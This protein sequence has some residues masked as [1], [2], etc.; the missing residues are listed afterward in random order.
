MRLFPT[1]S[2][3]NN[4][5]KGCKLVS[6]PTDLSAVVD[7][8]LADSNGQ[9]VVKTP[10]EQDGRVI[11][12]YT[13]PAHPGKPTILLC[14]IRHKILKLLRTGLCI[15]RG[16]VLPVQQRQLAL[17]CLTT[18]TEPPARTN[19]SSYVGS[20][21]GLFQAAVGGL[22]LPDE[23]T[24]GIPDCT[25]HCAAQQEWAQSGRL[26]GGSAGLRCGKCWTQARAEH[27]CKEQT[28]W[29]AGGQGKSAK[30]LL[31]R[32]RWATLGPNFNWTG[33]LTGVELGSS[34]KLNDDVLM[35]CRAKI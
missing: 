25:C 28:G 5:R 21:P 12:A 34:V 22:S 3:R 9:T 2:R 20:L 29:V 4:R 7:L 15:I 6:R 23:A 10:L 24:G 33:E 17:Q 1:F 14:P 18:F 30:S 13:L 19:H 26:D 11:T 35:K 16:L 32:L 31:K 8:G 27:C